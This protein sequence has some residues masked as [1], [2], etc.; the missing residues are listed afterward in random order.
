IKD[1]ILG[2]FRQLLRPLVRILLRNGISWAEYAETAKM[3]FVEVA[4]KDFGLD[5][6]R[7]SASRIAILTGLTREEVERVTADLSQ[8]GQPSHANLN[9]VG[10][11]LAGWH[12]DPDFTGPYGLPLELDVEG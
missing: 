2:A 4:A 3:V 1:T 11:V 9:R 10:R 5:G 6:Q 12:Q 8:R 7:Q